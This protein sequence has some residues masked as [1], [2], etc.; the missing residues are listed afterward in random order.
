MQLR[1]QGNLITVRW[2]A[3]AWDSLEVSDSEVIGEL[4]IEEFQSSAESM[5]EKRQMQGGVP[6]SENQVPQPL[7]PPPR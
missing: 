1:Y 5:L 2:T 6:G 7:F 4:D 3:D